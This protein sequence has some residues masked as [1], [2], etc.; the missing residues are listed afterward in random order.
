MDK[1]EKITDKKIVVFTGPSLHPNKASEILIADYRPPVGR[2][3]ILTALKDK[4]DV[5]AIIDGVFHQKPAVSHKEILKALKEG[6][7]VVGGASMGALRAS[8]LDD[9][10]MIGVGRV[11]SYYKGGLIEADDDVAVV[12]NPKTLEQ[13]SE[14]LVTMGYNFKAA[15]NEKL[16]SE[17]DFKTLIQTAKSIYYPKRTYRKV[18]SDSGIDESKKQVLERFLDERS[19]DVKR[20]DAVEVL[21]YIKKSL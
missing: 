20:E 15:L 17:E 2:G 16:I 5:I 3:D 12:F 9:F 8:E 1:N 21:E 4:P 11:Y 18:L 10:G 6:V 7:T 14:A 13:L 19:V